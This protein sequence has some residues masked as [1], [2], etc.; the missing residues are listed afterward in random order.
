MG[1]G[2]GVVFSKHSLSK[3]INKQLNSQAE[4]RWKR[5]EF[6]EEEFSQEEVAGRSGR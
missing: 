1:L 3:A 6:Q 4:K 2:V 5:E